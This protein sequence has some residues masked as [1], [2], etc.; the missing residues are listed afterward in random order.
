MAQFWDALNALTCEAL[1][2]VLC[3][4]PTRGILSSYPPLGYVRCMNSIDLDS[5]NSTSKRQSL[6]TMLGQIAATIAPLALQWPRRRDSV[7]RDIAL[8]VLRTV[9]SAVA[10]SCLALLLSGCE[11]TTEIVTNPPGAKVTINGKFIGLSPVEFDVSRG[12]WPDDNRFVYLIE[13][14]G[15]QPTRGEFRGEVAPGRIVGSIFASAGLSLAWNGVMV[16]PEVVIDLEPM[17]P[18]LPARGGAGLTT[19]ERLQRVN[20][21]YSEGSITEQERKRLRSDILSNEP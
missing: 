21:L 9:V 16:L 5:V 17:S 19:A 8:R 6:V 1:R 14:E 12:D 4:R 3:A 18:S 13:R 15:F 11:E 10:L 7:A 20:D 2:V